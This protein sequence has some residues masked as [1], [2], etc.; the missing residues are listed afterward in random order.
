MIYRMTKGKGGRSEDLNWMRG[1]SGAENSKSLH[2]A[3]FPL[4]HFAEAISLALSSR[5]GLLAC[6]WEFTLY[7]ALTGKRVTSGKDRNATHK[8]IEVIVS[9]LGPGYFPLNP[10]SP[11]A[12]LYIF[13]QGARLGLVAS[14]EYDRW[15]NPGNVAHTIQS[16]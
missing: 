5:P 7:Y 1:N 8:A 13:A 4:P 9:P 11:V 3:V 15:T 16:I 2:A 12:G 6:V 14:Q 10:V